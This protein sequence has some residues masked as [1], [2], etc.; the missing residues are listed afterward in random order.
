MKF[1]EWLELQNRT[2]NRD[3]IFPPALDAQLAVDF[4][5]K[6]LLGEDWYTVNPISTAQINTEI[7]YEILRKY[8]K[9]FRK[10]LRKRKKG[11]E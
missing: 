4:L 9:R 10:E 1:L 11:S 2:V 5:Q 8:S 3:N 7:V 6:Y